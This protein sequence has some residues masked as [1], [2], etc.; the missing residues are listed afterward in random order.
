MSNLLVLWNFNVL[1][2]LKHAEYG[3]SIHKNRMYCTRYIL[4]SKDA[5]QHLHAFIGLVSAYTH[6]THARGEGV[7]HGMQ[8]LADTLSMRSDAICAITHEAYS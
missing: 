7:F 1:K 6:W 3:N 2:T 5:S 4:H 8:M